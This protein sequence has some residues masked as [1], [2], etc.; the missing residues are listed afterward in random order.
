MPTSIS[1]TKTAIAAPAA[2]V[3]AELTDLRGFESWL[4]HSGSY[5]G[6]KE[7][8]SAAVSVGTTYRE[9]TSA[10]PMTGRVAEFEPDRLV[11]FEQQTDRGD[12]AIRIRYVLSPTDRG[13]HI[14]RT[15]RITTAGRL[16]LLHPL[17]VFAIRG[18][19]RR[20]LAKLKQAV[21]A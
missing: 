21:E 6:T 7:V 19:N 18:E 5:R 4:P 17:I 10:G 1:I 3:F 20:T 2:T 14:T 16:R 13:V 15:G 8:S 12:L 9:H 11:T